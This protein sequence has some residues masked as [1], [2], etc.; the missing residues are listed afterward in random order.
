MFG[1]IMIMLGTISLIL[2]VSPSPGYLCL[3]P[4]NICDAIYQQYQQYVVQ[5]FIKYFLLGS[6]SMTLSIIVLLLGR[7]KTK[8]THPT[9]RI[10]GD[11]PWFDKDS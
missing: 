11:R 6:A 9:A 5:N 1:L 7:K 2:S 4:Q 10:E 3:A 8:E